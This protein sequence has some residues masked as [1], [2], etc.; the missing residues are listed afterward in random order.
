[1]KSLMYLLLALFSMGVRLS[2]DMTTKILLFID[3]TLPQFHPGAKITR[4]RSVKIAKPSK[5]ANFLAKYDMMLTVD[6][7]VCDL[8]IRQYMDN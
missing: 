1:M 5:H 3:I 2:L 7:L 6:N 8:D 4:I